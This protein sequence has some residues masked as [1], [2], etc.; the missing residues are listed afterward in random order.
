MAHIHTLATL[1]GLQGCLWAQ[2]VSSLASLRCFRFGALSSIW[3]G[4]LLGGAT[5][6]PTGSEFLGVGAD[7]GRGRKGSRFSRA[8]QPCCHRVK[9]PVCSGRVPHFTRPREPGGQH[10]ELA[11]IAVLMRDKHLRDA[12]RQVLLELVSAQLPSLLGSPSLTWLTDTLNP[13]PPICHD[14]PGL[15]SLHLAPSKLKPSGG[16]ILTRLSFSCLADE[17]VR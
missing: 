14:G 9:H 6:C 5:G 8:A 12:G 1:S 2:T 13:C 15:A 7:E 10:R 16:Q 17:E 11:P 4:S 3:S